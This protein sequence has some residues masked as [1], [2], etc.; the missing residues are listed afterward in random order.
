MTKT[1]KYKGS[2][3]NRTTA[4]KERAQIETLARQGETVILDYSDVISLSGS[5]ADELFGIFTQRYGA[6]A[7]K[8]TIKVQGASSTVARAIGLAIQH[9]MPA[10]AA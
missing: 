6:Q 5:Y 2:L 8:T 3:A 7:L 1:L 9:R 10:N 4:A